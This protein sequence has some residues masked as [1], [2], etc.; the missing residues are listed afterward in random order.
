MLP[1]LIQAQ[2]EPDLERP[3]A[4]IASVLVQIQ[5]LRSRITSR[6]SDHRAAQ[7]Q[8]PAQIRLANAIRANHNGQS[9]VEFQLR[10]CAEGQEILS[11]YRSSEHLPSN[12]AGR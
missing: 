11:P 1:W 4:L 7:I 2:A 5:P 8:A 3:G 10:Q 6:A 12:P 9:G